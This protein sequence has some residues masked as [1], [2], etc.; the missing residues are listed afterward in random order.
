M[1]YSTDDIKALDIKG[2]IKASLYDLEVVGAPYAFWGDET[3]LTDEQRAAAEAEGIDNERQQAG[4]VYYWL[5]FALDNAVAVRLHRIDKEAAYNSRAKQQALDRLQRKD[6]CHIKGFT[7]IDSALDIK[8]H[9]LGKISN[10]LEPLEALADYGGT[11]ERREQLRKEAEAKACNAFCFDEVFNELVELSLYQKLTQSKQRATDAP[12]EPQPQREPEPTAPDPVAKQKGKRGRKKKNI[13]A[14]LNAIN[15]HTKEQVLQA[16]QTM[17]Q[18][19]SGYD[20]LY[21]ILAAMKL[22][23]LL[24]P[25]YTEFEGD[26]PNTGNSNT[27][28]YAFFNPN[29]VPVDEKMKAAMKALDM[30]LKTL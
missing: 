11:K 18:G 8:S 14:K 6:Y 17:M 13:S 28:F 5:C 30:Y 19:K 26:F 20:A 29:F 9:F 2:F 4:M 1:K 24:Q 10:R 25:T 21:F 7:T 23:Y 16:L 15:G 22:G 12:T 3:K 27:N